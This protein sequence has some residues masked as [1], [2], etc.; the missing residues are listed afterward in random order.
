MTQDII[1]LNYCQFFLSLLPL[2][3]PPLR[4]IAA[5]GK[6]SVVPFSLV[7][8]AERYNESKPKS[9]LPS[10]PPAFITCSR[11]VHCWRAFCSQSLRHFFK[12]WKRWLK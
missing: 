12:A 11:I 1:F 5:S 3:P 6:A 10:R 9:F 8:P 7:H 2:K 4:A